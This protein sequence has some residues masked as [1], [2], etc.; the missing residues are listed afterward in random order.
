MT[1][2]ID[3]SCKG[4]SQARRFVLQDRQSLEVGRSN[5]E[6]KLVSDARLSRKHFSV[7]Y[8][9]GR[10]EVTH[11]SRTNPTL[12]AVEGSSDFQ[13][14]RGSQ[15]EDRNCRLIAGSH[16]FVLTIEK[17]DSVI[18]P[19]LSGEEN[20]DFWSDV[21]EQ[22]PVP[23]SDGA[24]ASDGPVE[25]VRGESPSKKAVAAAVAEERAAE[26]ELVK[27]DPPSRAGS[28][29]TPAFGDVFDDEADDDDW[30]R[31]HHRKTRSGDSE[32]PSP[33]SDQ[34]GGAAFG[35]VFDEDDE[36]DSQRDQTTIHG[37]RAAR[38]KKAAA[39]KPKPA[40]PARSVDDEDDTGGRKK[41]F[42]PISDDFFDD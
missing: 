39:A 5:E 11:H 2:V 42:F 36:V 7:R 1:L 8:E 22:E 21:D 26:R 3:V 16:R 25:T 12:I 6:L 9:G 17:P 27:T 13:K 14:V 31:D 4:S 19:T 38:D 33:T 35:S 40:P 29:P 30:G 10:I 32:A 28:S 34:R 23:K 15:W 37:Q 24:F 18:A 41:P 20:S